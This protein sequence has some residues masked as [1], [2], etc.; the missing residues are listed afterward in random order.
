MQSPDPK[1]DEVIKQQILVI[2]TAVLQDL[3]LNKDL[4]YESSGY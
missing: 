2:D 4:L 1:K 3:N